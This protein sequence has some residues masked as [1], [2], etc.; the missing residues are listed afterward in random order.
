MTRDHLLTEG[1]IARL[2][3]A[4]AIHLEWCHDETGT[5]YACFCGSE[6]RVALIN[7]I[8]ARH[9][10]EAVAA[11]QEPGPDHRPSGSA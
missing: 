8:I 5:C 4:G 6:S 9:V 11:A 2:D 3:V 10:A 7:E 1:E